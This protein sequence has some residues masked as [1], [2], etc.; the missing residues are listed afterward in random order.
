[1]VALG[2]AGDNQAFRSGVLWAG[3]RNVRCSA[4]APGLPH[5]AAAPAMGPV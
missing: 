3:R 2:G 5:G 1:V 4:A